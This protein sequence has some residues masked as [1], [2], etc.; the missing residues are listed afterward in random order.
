MVPSLRVTLVEAK[1]RGK[2]IADVSNSV[3][4]RTV[5]RA[6]LINQMLAS[7]PSDVVQT[8]RRLS[9]ITHLEEGQMQLS[10]EDGSVTA[11]DGLV[12]CDG[13]NSFVRKHIFGAD[14]GI[15][16]AEYTPGFNTRMMIPDSEAREIFGDEYC[17]IR[18]Q[19][20]W[21]GPGTFCMTDFGDKGDSMQVVTCFRG[22]QAK[23][24]ED[25]PF[26]WVEKDFWLERIKDHGW[27]GECVSKVIER[28]ESVF[29]AGWRGH[30]PPARY[31]DQSSCVAGDA[32]WAFA[33]ARGAGASQGIEDALMLT[34]VLSCV[35]SARDV[36]AAFEVYD[37]LRRPRRDE[38]ADESDRAL[39]ILCG[40]LP[41]VGTDEHRLKREFADWNGFIYRYNLVDAQ[42]RAR[43]MMEKR[44][45]A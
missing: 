30:R 34:T 5:I 33:P 37:G 24:M 21:I 14:V 35:R 4:Q 7:L 18:T 10:F 25:T 38:V 42:S 45:R 28:Q 8:G 9:N 40:C 39:D 6:D 12:G 17:N 41:G 23:D 31:C 1:G 11:A 2:H 44:V 19:S 16:D 43:E 22:E 26:M 36:K 29:A 20:G 32:A 3:P 15:A 27:I 13:I